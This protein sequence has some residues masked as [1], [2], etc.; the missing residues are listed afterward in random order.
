MAADSPS[1]KTLH[2]IFHRKQTNLSPHFE[3]PR[4]GDGIMKKVE[5]ANFLGVSLEQHLSCKEQISNVSRKLGKYV[6]IMYASRQYFSTKSFR[7]IWNSLVHSNL[8]YSS[9][10]WG[11]RIKTALQPLYIKQNKIVRGMAGVSLYEPS[12]QFFTEIWLHVLDNTNIYKT[13]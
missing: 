1:N 6:H 3:C 11:L 8:I 4:F 12:H 2:M 7:L 10:I 13:A 5:N 9:R